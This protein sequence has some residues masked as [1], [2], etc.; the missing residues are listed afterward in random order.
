M[1]S[2][3]MIQRAALLRMIENDILFMETLERLYPRWRRPLRILNRSWALWSYER[4]EQPWSWF[5]IRIFFPELLDPRL[6]ARGAMSV[7][8]TWQ[9]KLVEAL[10]FWPVHYL[11]RPSRLRFPILKLWKKLRT[12]VVI[13]KHTPWI[14]VPGIED[15]NRKFREWENRMLRGG[16]MPQPHGDFR[17]AFAAMKKIVE[18]LP[19]G[20]FEA[21]TDAHGTEGSGPNDWL[22]G[23][24]NVKGEYQGHLFHLDGTGL[25]HYRT[26]IE[27]DIAGTVFMSELREMQHVEAERIREEIETLG[28]NTCDL[29][30]KGPGA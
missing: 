21:T 10:F 23:L 26:R 13:V 14:E 16:P 22:V 27:A 3:E 20:I 6:N 4:I 5:V 8:K 18:A 17:T 28:L 25:I 9:F 15:E 11:L 2:N 19:G 12:R 7:V 24:F 30:W 29:D 1:D